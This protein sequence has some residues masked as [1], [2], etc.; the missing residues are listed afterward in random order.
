MSVPVYTL[1]PGLEMRFLV[2][3]FL[4]LISVPAFSIDIRSVREMYTRAVESKAIT[5]K[6]LDELEKAPQTPVITGYLGATTILQAKHAFNPFNK[7]SYFK[8]GTRILENAIS[9]APA[10]VE[11]RFL[12]Y[13]VQVNVP[14]ILN[15]NSKKDQDRAFLEGSL[16]ENKIPDSHLRRGIESFLKKH[17]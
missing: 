16:K 11:L 4:L 13:A 9:R 5:H 7:L 6:L 3:L 8:T 17:G 12:R 14:A 15:Y 10:E 1:Q 2:C